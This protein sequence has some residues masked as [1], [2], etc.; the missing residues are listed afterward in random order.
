VRQAKKL[1]NTNKITRSIKRQNRRTNED[2][3][4]EEEEENDQATDMQIYNLER[5]EPS[6]DKDTTQS[7]TI[8]PRT[9]ET[10]KSAE[11]EKEPM[12]NKTHNTKQPQ[13]N[14]MS[15]TEIQ[16]YNNT[17]SDDEPDHDRRVRQRT[18][19]E[20]YRKHT[21]YP[22]RQKRTHQK[23]RN[24]TQKATWKV[25]VQSATIAKQIKQNLTMANKTR[26]EIHTKHRHGVKYSGN[27]EFD[28]SNK[29]QQ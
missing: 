29:Q 5:D 13:P 2:S 8:R 17:S 10:R 24:M 26:Q 6:T 28:Q 18:N 16:E 22:Y 15:G 25:R 3:P 9:R 19:T 12:N 27:I 20:G 14:I 7:D 11:R 4:E 21:S 1:P 23:T